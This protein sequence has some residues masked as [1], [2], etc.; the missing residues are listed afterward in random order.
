MLRT[1]FAMPSRVFYSALARSILAGE[2][3]RRQSNLKPIVACLGRTLGRDWRWLRPLVRRYFETFGADTRPTRKAVAAFLA[4]DEGLK[5]AIHRHVK[6]I[7]IA[8]WMREP[9]RMQPARAARKW[10]IPAINSVGELADWIG[11]TTDDLMCFAN[12][13][14]FPASVAPDGRSAPANHYHYHLLTKTGGGIRLIEAPKQRLK[15]IQNRILRGILNA[16][17]VHAAVHGFRRGFSITTFAAPHVARRVVLRLDLR[18]FF[19]S[20]TRVRVQ[21]MFRTAGYPEPVADLL[22]GL[23]TNVAPRGIFSSSNFATDPGVMFEARQLYGVPHLPQGA[24]TSSALS[25]ICAYRLDC[26]LAGLAKA[27]DALYTRYAD[28]LA[29]SGAEEFDRHAERFAIHAAAIALE[30]G[31]NVNH[32]KSRVMCSSVRQHLAGLVVNDHLNIARRDLDRLKATLTNCVRHGPA[33]QNRD[34]HPAFRS[35]LDGRVGFVETVNAARG[36]R[37]REIFEQIQW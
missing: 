6:Q 4:Q 15:E 32:R 3:A 5:D 12:L 28:D 26:R 20:L 2:P 35:H 10:P 19:P 33:S 21:A 31:F 17:P 14:S 1:V 22:G 8:D 37:L 24:P 18:D 29:F 9:D 30:E 16:I 25:N 27:S 23:C 11:I 7:R 13:K 34:G 36:S